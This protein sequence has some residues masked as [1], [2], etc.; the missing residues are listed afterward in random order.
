MKISSNNTSFSTP[1]TTNPIEKTEPI[2]EITSSNN[3]LTEIAAE[4]SNLNE[5]SIIETL[6]DMSLLLGSRWHDENKK[7]EFLT[8]QGQNRI[9]RIL[10][11]TQ[12]LSHSN[13]RDSKVSLL[14]ETVEEQLQRITSSNLPTTEQIALLTGLWRQCNELDPA[15]RH[16]KRRILSLLSKDGWEVA[17]FGVIEFG[18]L[19]TDGFGAVRALFQE[20]LHKGGMTITEWFNQVRDWPERRKRICV[21]LRALAYSLSVNDAQA[22]RIR[23]ANIIHQ[24]RRLSLF[25]SLESDCHL[26]DLT[27]LRL[28]QA[29][30]KIDSDQTIT[31]II[32]IIEQ[33]WVFPDWLIQSVDLHSLPTNIHTSYLNQLYQLFS[34]LPE[35][36]FNEPDQ[37][38]QIHESILEA[39]DSVN[40]PNR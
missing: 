21:L 11:L 14:Q 17:L 34:R 37:R 10:T 3:M 30:N 25:L 12:E 5:A 32:S 35:A 8:K 16:V 28:T 2:S 18:K 23:I 38:N 9:L 39:I 19:P 31:R 26:F 29:E 13:I 33:P 36:C 15:H 1:I 22:E 4:L 20:S 40:A 27:L 6:E 7:R 24:L